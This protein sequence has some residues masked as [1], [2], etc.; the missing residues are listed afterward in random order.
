MKTSYY[1]LNEVLNVTSALYEEFINC[2]KD[3]TNLKTLPQYIYDTYQDWYALIY[4]GEDNET[5]VKAAEIA[6]LGR[7]E[8][9]LRRKA[10]YW[11]DYISRQA[12]ISGKTSSLQRYVD[13][14]ETAEDYSGDTHITNVTKSETSTDNTVGLN[15]L[16]PYYDMMMYEFR[17]QWLLPKEAI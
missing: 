5:A 9:W 14:P 3:Y 7:L 13:T 2:L 10:I 16:K 15:T 1:T 12:A 11:N 6:Q 4:D 17:K 8:I